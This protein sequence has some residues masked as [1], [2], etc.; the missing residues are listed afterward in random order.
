MIQTFSNYDR[1]ELIEAGIDV[2]DNVRISKSVVFYNPQ[3]ITIGNNVRIDYGC[4]LIAGKDTKLIIK[5]NTHIN[6]YCSFHA[7]TGD[8]I[9]GKEVDIAIYTV[10]FTATFDYSIKKPRT[11]TTVGSIVIEDN[12]IVGPS[13][14]ILPN[15]VL[16]ESCSV[17]ANSF[18]K[19]NVDRETIVAG[20]PCKLIKN[21]SHIKDR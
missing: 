17:G 8:I 7:N 2:G 11:N 15:S 5:D 1:H 4:L 14:I 16:G 13:C 21:K 6:A 12:V 3:N 18:I 9:I 20:N 19:N 10:L